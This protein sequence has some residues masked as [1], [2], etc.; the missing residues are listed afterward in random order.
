MKKTVSVIKLSEFYL[1]FNNA[2][3]KGHL[4]FYVFIIIINLWKISGNNKFN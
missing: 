1:C 3:A 4:S 2:E